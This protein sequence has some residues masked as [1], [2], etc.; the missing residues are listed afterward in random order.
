MQTQTIQRQYDDIIAPHYD[1]DPQR[2]TG[3]SLDRATEQLR[4]HDLLDGTRVRLRVLDLGIGTGLFLA[5][6]KALAGCDVEP[7]GVDLSENMIAVARR[8]IPELVAVVDDAARFDDHFPGQAFDLICTH[9]ITG[10]IPLDQLAPR[11]FSRLDDGGWFSL[12]G[13]TKAG[14]PALQAKAN[15]R[16]FRW[17]LGGGRTLSVDELVCNPAGREEIVTT[18]ESHGFT[19]R[20]CETF[21]PK[22]RFANVAEFME[23]GYQGGW[24]TPFIEALGLHQ[25]GWLTRSLMNLFFFPVEDYH[26]IEIV[27]AQKVGR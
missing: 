24:F 2:V 27:L 15:A 10:F 25:I 22:L 12:V 18:L 16:R 26:S 21:E 20:A 23:F 19:V 4:Y 17:V 3:R 9:F 7:F 8:R 13:G 5:K 11:I 1:L 14:F 6:L